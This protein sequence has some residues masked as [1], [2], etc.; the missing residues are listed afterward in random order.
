MRILF[1]IL[2]AAATVVLCYILNTSSV[3]PAP[4]GKLLSP[5]HGIW[6]NAEPYNADFNGIEALPGL[7][8]KVDVFFDERLVPHVFAE[9]TIDA[10]Y[11][12]G[13]IHAKFRLWQMELQTHVAAGRL[14]EIAGEKALDRDREFRRLGMTYAAEKAL[15]VLEA[16]ADLKAQCDAYTAGVNAYIST[17]T[18]SSLPLEYKLMGYYP[19]KWS[20]YKTALFL[21]LMAYDLLSRDKDFEMT[22]ALAFFGR[23]KFKLLFP[24][25]SETL[26]PII[27]D[28]F[29]ALKI[30]RLQAPVSYDTINP[31]STEVDL[32]EKPEPELGSNNWAVG[33]TKTATQDVIVCN[34]PHLGL[35]LP[36]LWFEMQITTPDFSSYGVTFPGSPA[37]IIGFN[38]DIAWGLTNGGRDVKDYYEIKF[39]DESKKEYLFNGEWLPTEFRYEVIHII[40]QNEF[41]DTVM[42]TI[43]G[44]V[45][46]DTKYHDR[47]DSTRYYAVRWL[48]HDPGKELMTFNLLNR[49]KNYEDY[50]EATSHFASPGQNFVFGSRNGDIALRTQGAWPMKWFEQGDF[51]MPGWDSTYLWKGTIPDSLIPHQ[52]NPERGFVSSA[53]QHPADTSYPYYLGTDYPVTRGKIINRML[54]EKN[55]ITVDEMKTMQVDNYNIF[56][57]MAMPILMK[58]IQPDELTPNMMKYY[59]ILK[60]WDLYNEPNSKGMTVFEVVWNSFYK[61]VYEDEYEN[62]PS[63]IARPAP[64][65]LIEAIAKDTNYVFIDRI[66]TRQIENLYDIATEAFRKSIGQLTELDAGGKLEW[67]RYKGTRVLHLAQ[68]E[69][70]SRMEL[71]IGG[72]ANIINAT[73][74]KTGPSW[75]MVVR[76][77]NEIEAY[78]VYPGG[79]SGNPGS[80][81]YDNFVDTWVKGQ[82]YS[83]QIWKSEE[84]KSA[85][86]KMTFKPA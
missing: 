14:S 38:E 46:Y 8:G 53:N 78:G 51:V 86:W 30:P 26:D 24:A 7:K 11:V 43:H 37:I 42:Y 18:E 81:Y 13:F 61:T 67:Y 55:Q 3:L 50:L 29:N 9:N 71:P 28:N 33:P 21:K 17:L 25:V 64:M 57:E 54:T 49:A 15:E 84:T 60:G 77:G 44:P 79:Q 66:N 83:I 56:A 75:R 72:G 41:V 34:D 32:M 10:Y 48:P 39:K 59:E 69:P 27:P 52:Y 47:S 35:N 45:I 20:N 85:K 16:D 19:E 73:T 1:T 31:L 5:Q 70:L 58:Y 76:L 74:T 6:Q 4:L 65:T 12:Q 62:A 82:Y 2:S 23:E 68:L 63:V 22:N 80:K 36:S 40:G